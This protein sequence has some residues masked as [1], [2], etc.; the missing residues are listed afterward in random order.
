[1]NAYSLQR[2]LRL[3]TG[4]ACSVLALSLAACGGAASAP[5]SSAPASAP[6]LASAAVSGAPASAAA[7]PASASAGASAKPAAGG[8]ISLALHIPITGV[9]A[10][11][12]V[13]GK[14]GAQM[15]IDEINA[16]GGV[17]I[18]SVFEDA[19]SDP[20]SATNSLNKL[21][22]GKKPA[23]VISTYSTPQILAISPLIKQNEVPVFNFNTGTIS[24]RQGN[25]WL[26][27][28]YIND[29][30]RAAAIVKYT[31][32]T[33]KKSKIATL[34]QNDDYGNGF[35]K[36]IQAQLESRG[37]KL[38]A[39]ESFG[40]NDK[41]MSAQILKVKNANPGAV[42]LVSSPAP[43]AIV[44]KQARQQGLK[45]TILGDS[46]LSSPPF[47]G[48]LS[49]QEADGL[50][51]FVPAVPTSS[52]DAKVQ[53]WVKAYQTKFNTQPDS[54]SLAYYD[55]VGILAEAYAKVGPDPA[56]LREAIAGMKSY[57]GVMFAYS[58]DQNGDGV[59]SITVTQNKGKTPEVLDTINA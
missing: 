32:D 37:V 52:K 4:A 38:E 56:K 26:F 2:F 9:L 16:K 24:N 18:D 27:R 30:L 5:A 59:H 43:G 58:F 11:N 8:A 7:K 49:D 19:G 35:D 12:G 31:L 57:Q 13:N 55:A 23:A 34:H 51:S 10:I 50:Y 54:Y 44:V 29:D 42:F 15:R 41:D 17:K 6:A 47:L 20:N 45:T 14:N 21:L 48:L 3:P 25:T 53:D 33:L 46:N 36:G 1:M 22:S 39:D 40:Q 28:P